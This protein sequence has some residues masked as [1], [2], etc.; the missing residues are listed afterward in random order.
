MIKWIKKYLLN[1]ELKSLSERTLA[2]NERRVK[3]VH[4]PNL[5]EIPDKLDMC[6]EI[7]KELKKI[8]KK[9]NKIN[10]KLIEYE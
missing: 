5:D 7:A 1:R 4:Q 9:I 10:K 8:K 3:L 6:V 2:L